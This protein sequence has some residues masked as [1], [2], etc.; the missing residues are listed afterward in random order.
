MYTS[1]IK[2]LDTKTEQTVITRKIVWIYGAVTL[3][4]IVG[5]WNYEKFSY[6]EYSEYMRSMFWFPLVGGMALGMLFVKLERTVARWSFLLW[7]SGIAVLTV[8]CLV[9][10]I[11]AISGRMSVYDLYYWISGIAFLLVAMVV[12]VRTSKRRR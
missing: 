9:H 6:G 8:G 5:T 10:G 1:D 4:C 11:I 12:E 2:T 7:N 3:F